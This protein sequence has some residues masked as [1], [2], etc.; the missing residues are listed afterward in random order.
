MHY[1]LDV[2]IDGPGGGL[3]SL[4]V[5]LSCYEVSRLGGVEVMSE[6]C[7]CVRDVGSSPAAA[8]CQD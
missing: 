6:L 2:M 3:G 7:R 8:G 1:Y 5:L 4:E